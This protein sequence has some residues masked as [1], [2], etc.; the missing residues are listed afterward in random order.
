MSLVLLAAPLSGLLVQPLIGHYADHSTSQ[1]GRRRPFMFVG[2]LIAGLSMFTLGYGKP[3]MEGVF[4]A[5]SSLVCSITTLFG[6]VW[7]NAH[8]MQAESFTIAL[9][10]I[11]VY[12]VDFSVNA[13]TSPFPSTCR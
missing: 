13:G 9:A 10:V 7:T 6:R 1:Y 8:A 2:S 5:G 11:S 12:V 4:G 3:L